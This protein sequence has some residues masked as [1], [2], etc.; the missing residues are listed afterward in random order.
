MG[1][2]VRANPHDS[3]EPSGRLDSTLTE[4]KLAGSLETADSLMRSLTRLST[5]ART[6]A[7][8]LDT[9]LTRVNRGEGSLGRFA[10]DTTFY[11]ETRA[12]LRAL[13]EFID[14]LRKN[15]GKLNIRFT[16]F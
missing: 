13:K 4:L 12:T 1:R 16:I 14:D 10:T 7:E 15:P 5:D 2:R 6:T 3:D 11:V 8:R 9:T